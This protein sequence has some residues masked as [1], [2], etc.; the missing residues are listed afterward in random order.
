MLP[1]RTSDHPKMPTTS[2]IPTD[3]LSLNDK[4]LTLQD[5]TRIAYHVAGEG[6]ALVLTN[7]LTTTTSFWKYTRPIWLQRHTVVT[8]DLPGHGHSGPARSARTASVPGQ[9]EIVAQVMRAAGVER[10]AQ[11]GWSTG[12]GVVAELYRQR[13]ELCTALVMVLGGAGHVL[14]TTRLPVGGSGIDWLATH[15]PA[16]VFAAT[17]GLLARSFQHP[18]ARVVARRF[19]LVG[20]GLSAQDM[21]EFTAHIAQ[22]DLGTLQQLLH[23][24]QVHSAHDALQTLRVPLLIVAGDRDAFAPTELVGLPL[25]RAVRNSEL[26]RLPNGTHTA[27]LEEPALIASEVQKFLE[28]VPAHQLPL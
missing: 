21:V 14:D 20:A 7:G 22:V 9:P 2:S 27:L 3:P 23:S 19:G 11:I 25:Q 28:R 15:L 13:P 6:P 12:A 24:C 1:R 8:W 4:F 5:G 18:S 16:P 17:A 10:A 26:L